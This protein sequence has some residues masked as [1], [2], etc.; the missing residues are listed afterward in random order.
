[1]RECIGCLGIDNLF[2]QPVWREKG[3]EGWRGALEFHTG[4]ILAAELL[5][6]PLFQLLTSHTAF[7]PRIVSKGM[8]Q[9]ENRKKS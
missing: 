5:S 1:M 2:S 4:K 7:S 9:Q 3:A 6:V 8:Q